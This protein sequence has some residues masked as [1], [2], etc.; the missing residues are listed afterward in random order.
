M[1]TGVIGKFLF[2]GE[3]PIDDGGE[4]LDPPFLPCRRPPLDTLG[5]TCVA[6]KD[7]LVASAVRSYTTEERR[8]SIFAISR[9]KCF[10]W[11]GTVE[12]NAAFEWPTSRFVRELNMWVFTVGRLDCILEGLGGWEDGGWG[13]GGGRTD[14]HVRLLT[15][16]NPPLRRE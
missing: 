10:P 2:V 16:L 1:D 11:I 12:D 14:F 4:F 5:K 9:L 3:A 15:K 6:C 7:A 8:R 13:D